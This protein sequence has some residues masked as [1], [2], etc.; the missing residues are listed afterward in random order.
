MSSN[1]SGADRA[2]VI[3]G[4]LA[5]LAIPVDI[6]VARFL[7]GIELVQSLVVAVPVSALL[8]LT[9]LSAARRGRYARARSVQ[10]TGGRWGS[11]LAWLGLYCA[12]TGAVALAV[13]G[14]LRAAE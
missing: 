7:K 11:R 12:L 2:A 4:A 9:A 5:V 3:F 1:K 6:V 13:Y 8:A 14:G 10:L